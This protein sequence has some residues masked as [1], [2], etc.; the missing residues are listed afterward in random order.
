MKGIELIHNGKPVRVGVKDGTL[1]I[2]VTVGQ[3]CGDAVRANG[4]DYEDGKDNMWLNA[5]LETGDVLQVKAVELDAFDA[6]VRSK[7]YVRPQKVDKLKR[8]YELEDELKKKGL[9]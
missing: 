3:K 5:P 9:L 4:Y 6:P 2:T 7:D 8:F 1:L